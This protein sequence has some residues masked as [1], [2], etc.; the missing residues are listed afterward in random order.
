MNSAS[1]PPNGGPFSK[2]L[3]W[4]LAGRK[5]TP[6]A[7]SLGMSG[8]TIARL[9]AGE[10]TPP[11]PDALVRILHAEAVSLSWLLAGVGEPFH[12]VR[13]ESDAAA[14]E[15][16]AAE[17]EDPGWNVSLVS[18][19]KRNAIVL[20]QITETEHGKRHIRAMTSV[21]IACVVGENTSAVI[22]NHAGRV[23]NVRQVSHAVMH[24]IHAGYMGTWRL[25]SD[26]DGVVRPSKEMTTNE[27]LALMG[28]AQPA[29]DI[30]RRVEDRSLDFGPDVPPL[31]RLW[32]LLSYADREALR[33][34]MIP[35][36]EHALGMKF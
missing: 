24:T 22:A 6:W 13:P 25:V 15:L 4:L 3:E 31:V 19:A 36:L 7:Q 16:L 26:P 20:F 2:R 14:G 21:V 33:R 9:T 18:D 23:V 17:L 12:V 27:S 5:V 10:G 32:P 34:V 1:I 11:S 30:V 28:S 35:F 8:S 29:N